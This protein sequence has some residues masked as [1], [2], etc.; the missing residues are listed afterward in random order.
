MST[1]QPPSPPGVPQHLAQRASRDIVIEGLGLGATWP[2]QQ[3][4][5]IETE[6]TVPFGE[7]AAVRL[8]DAQSDVNYSLVLRDQPLALPTPP[9]V[10]GDV[11]AI[12]TPPV[13][14]DLTLG[15]MARK[16]HPSSARPTLE[17]S[18]PLAQSVHVKVGLDASLPVALIGHPRLDPALSKPTAEDS[19][20]V[21]YGD[22]V[23]VA[24]SRAQEGVQYALMRVSTKDPDV[25]EE[26]WSPWVDG[27]LDGIVLLG[28]GLREDTLLRVQ[29]RKVLN[30]SKVQTTWLNTVLSVAVEA[31][32][33]LPWA[34]DP[35]HG[36]AGQSVR[37]GLET[38]QRS[39]LY[40]PWVRPV[41]DAAWRF[42]PLPKDEELPIVPAPDGG[43]VRVP[44][45][46][47]RGGAAWQAVGKPREGA[48]GP[49]SLDVAMEHED[50]LVEIEVRKLHRASASS[51]KADVPTT[52]WGHPVGLL[53]V[54]PRQDVTLRLSALSDGSLWRL[55]GGQPGVRY[56]LLDGD[57]V[58]IGPLYVHRRCPRDPELNQGLGA[59]WVERSF[60][61]SCV[62]GAPDGHATAR[63]PVP[64][65]CIE[66]PQ[67]NLP[68]SL[69]VRA[70]MARSGV[71]VLLPDA[72]QVPPVSTPSE[73]GDGTSP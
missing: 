9:R 56:E 51:T 33:D 19:H 45:R 73:P 2:L 3:V 7:A 46:A 6:L 13:E 32:E 59:L 50:L 61:L 70:T 49:L 37:L 40:R 65:P 21:Q 8:C 57:R 16:R 34:S 14:E 5:P 39:A 43:Y 64:D 60:A 55:E 26:R 25:Q 52:V 23:T 66:R 36:A 71:T 24:L 48:D 67:G 10:E 35:A 28:Q 54:E 42:G 68:K 47:A 18:G 12:R 62:D 11:L 53:A 4:P 29:A 20:L 22:P 72:V 69:T 30:D 44:G 31:H 38:S 63:R 1:T 58:V 15:V 41:E 27:H 17:R